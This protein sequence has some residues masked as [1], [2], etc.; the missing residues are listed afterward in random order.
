MDGPADLTC[1]F[2][3]PEDC[4]WTNPSREEHPLLAAES[5][6]VD[7]AGSFELGTMTTG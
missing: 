6:S 7:R 5:I 4:C 1:D 3:V 2:E